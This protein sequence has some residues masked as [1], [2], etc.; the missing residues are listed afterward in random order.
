MRSSD[1][2]IARKRHPGI[3]LPNCVLFRLINS[4][5]RAATNFETFFGLGVV[6]WFSVHIAIHAGMNMGILPVTGITFP[7]MSY[8]GSHLLT[9]WLALG[10]LS[11]MKQHSQGPRL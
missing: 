5:E 8:G 1:K 7:L 10:M 11:S 6:V 9:E 4:A 3:F 2:L